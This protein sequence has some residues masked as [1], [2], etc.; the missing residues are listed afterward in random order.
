MPDP[1]T[2]RRYQDATLRERLA[3]E[4][5]LGT[6]SPRVQARLACLMARDPDWWQWV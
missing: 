5:V 1:M 4:Y 2:P 3:G 6:L